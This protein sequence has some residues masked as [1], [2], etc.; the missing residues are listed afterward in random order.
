[1][2]IAPKDMIVRIFFYDFKERTLLMDEAEANNYY[3]RTMPFAWVLKAGSEVKLDN[4]KINE[5]GVI[6]L[7][8]WRARTLINPRHSAFFNNEASN[9]N[10]ERLGVA[11]SLYVHRVHD[12]YKDRVVYIDLDKDPEVQDFYTFLLP[13]PEILGYFENPNDLINE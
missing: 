11:P 10:A 6:R 8:D 9:S 13:Q 3:I 2:I 4:V 1:M 7:Y 5:G 12:N